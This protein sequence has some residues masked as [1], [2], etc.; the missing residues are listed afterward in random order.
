M[1]YMHINNLYKDIDILMFK[2]CYALEKIHGTS[3]HISLKNGNMIYFSG[4]M[5]YNTFISIFNIEKIEKNFK[6]NFPDMDIT[7]YGEAYGGKCQGMSETYGKDAK[8][9]AFDVKVGDNWLSV[10]D[11]EDVVKK[12]ELEFVDYVKISTDLEKIDFERDKPST[13]AIRNGMGNDKLRE[14]VVLRPLIELRKNN[15]NRI[16]VKHKRAEFLE[17]ATKRKVEPDKLKV[18]T[19]A[20]EIAKEW[21]TPMRLSHVLDKLNNPTEIEKTPVVIKAMIEDITRE[22]EGEIIISPVVI[23]GIGK[24]TANLYKE[25]ISKIDRIEK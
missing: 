10:P 25:K 12:L 15:G 16:I 4:G 24:Y 17:T 20:D 2:E 11:A 13:Q 9:V 5:P 22:A 6:D 18:L 8:F 23:K 19:E 14:G 3:A 21:V 7:V 1:G